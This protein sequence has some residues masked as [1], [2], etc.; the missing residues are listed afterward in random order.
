MPT[1]QPGEQLGKPYSEELDAFAATYTWA[2]QQDVARLA[3]FL[4]R[5]SGDH[6]VVVGS[7]G[8]FSAAVVVALFRELAHHSQTAAVT[9]LDFGCLLQRLS[10]RAFLLSAEGKN[11]DILAAARAAEF[12]DLASAALTLTRSNPLLEL[13]RD[14]NAL[15]AFSF[16][17]DWVK[18]G[19]LA[20]NSL[21]ATVL[22]LYRAFFGDRDF[23]HGVAPLLDQKRLTARRAYFSQLPGLEEAKRRGLLVLH[24]ARAKAFAVDLESKLAESAL[25]T[26]QV[27]DLRQFAHGR[28]LQLVLRTP[29]PFVLLVSSTEERSLAVATAAHLPQ[30]ELSWQLELDGQSDQDVA[31]AGLLD[32][33]FLTEAL[34]RNASHDPGQP[35]VPEFGRAIHAIDSAALV[36]SNRKETSQVELAARR[37][38]AVGGHHV[39]APHHEVL[40]AARAYAAR[41]TSARIKAIVCDFD[42]T[43]CRAENRF[44]GMDPAHVEQISSLLRQG[45]TLAIATGRGGSLHDSLRS[46]FDS[47]LHGSI[48]VGYYSGSVIAPLDLAFYQPAANPEFEA[49]WDWLKASSYG[50]LCKPLNELARGGQLSM[51]LGSAH[52][53]ATLHAAIRTWLDRSGRRD[54]RVFCSGHSIDVL[55]ANTSKRLVVSHVAEQL[56]LD[57]LTQILRLGDSGHEQGNDFELLGEGLSLSCERVSFGLDSCWNFGAAGNNQAEVTMAY[58]RG[59]VR[60]DDAFRLSPSALSAS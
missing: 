4:T 54:W 23:Q 13:A 2:G 10:P 52:Q 26:V 40:S 16:Q 25:A 60:T 39:S 27:T 33:M 3:H 24:S 7:G 44:D 19:Y 58:L 55:D 34:S 50:Q 38:T 36:G 1:P 30:P 45:L 51:R 37:K 41:L 6:A 48:T 53:S 59:L 28:H 49:L 15:R 57:P 32:A 29:A 31:I 56:G 42:G 20:T 17:M 21:L 46:S 5:W 9:P 35:H 47:A 8:S 43:L 12:A 14:S 18:D 11:R 22:L